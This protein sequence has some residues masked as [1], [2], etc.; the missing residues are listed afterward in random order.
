M[1]HVIDPRDFHFVIKIKVPQ[2]KTCTE[3]DLLKQ[4]DY[5]TPGKQL[6]YS[7]KTGPNSF[8]TCKWKQ[9]IIILIQGVFEDNRLYICIKNFETFQGIFKDDESSRKKVYIPVST[10]GY[11]A[12]GKT[13][14]L[15]F[16]TKYQNRRSYVW[17][18]ILKP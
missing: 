2:I 18:K 7:I 10:K 9:F 5:I 8:Y 11:D 12:E 15:T 14:D 17:H 16:E 4:Y 6:H 13:I 1:A 3:E